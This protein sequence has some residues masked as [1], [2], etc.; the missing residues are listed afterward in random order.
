MFSRRNI[1]QR[2]REVDPG[3]GTTVAFDDGYVPG[4]TEIPSAQNQSDSLQPSFIPNTVNSQLLD[5][6]TEWASLSTFRTE[7][8]NPSMN[9]DPVN[10]DLAPTPTDSEQ[11]GQPSVT[12]LGKR[13]EEQSD[14]SGVFFLHS[15][16]SDCVVGLSYYCKFTFSSQRTDRPRATTPAGRFFNLQPGT[17]LSRTIA[18]DKSQ[19][20][21]SRTDSTGAGPDRGKS[22][23]G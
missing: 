11:A 14:V 7:Q 8:Q 15:W 1:E 18:V 9:L 19:C 4:A 20:S 6:Q 2:Q 3:A 13:R 21:E 22:N 10:D 12:A 16:C 5:A 17:T 23:K